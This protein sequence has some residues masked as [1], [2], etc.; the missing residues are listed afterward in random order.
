MGKKGKTFSD[1][2]KKATKKGEMSAL[3]MGKYTK[4]I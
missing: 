2:L 4:V 1:A 3:Q